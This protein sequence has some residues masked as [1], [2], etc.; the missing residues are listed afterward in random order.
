MKKIS[1]SVFSLFLFLQLFPQSQFSIHPEQK[2]SR[3]NSLDYFRGGE[4]NVVQTPLLNKYD[5][6]FYFLDLNVENDTSF[7]WGNVGIKA[8][9]LSAPLD[10]FALEFLD[11]MPIDSVFI[12]NIPRN[13]LRE[14][15]EIFIPIDPPID[16]GAVFSAK[17]YYH[18][19]PETGD[20]FSGG[21]TSR[22]DSTW[23]KHVTWSLSEPFYARSWWPV[24]QVL[25]DK[26]DSVWVFITTDSSN[27]AGSEGLLTQVVPL[28]PKHRFEW[29]SKYPIDYYL[30]SFAV[31][32]YQDY[33]I[34]AHPDGMGGDSLLI[35]NF[36]YDAPGCLEH[37]K[38]NLDR[39]VEIIELF[40]NL[41][42]LYPF[43]QEKYGHCLVPLGGGMEHQTMTT[44]GGFGLGIVAHE[45]GHMWF[46]DH[47]TCATW[48]D[49]WVNEGFATY[50]DYL[51]HEKIAGPPWPGI[52]MKNT[53]AYVISQPDGSIY[54]PPEEIT[55]D[56][57]HRIFDPLLSYNKGALILHMIRY[58]LHDDDL[59]FQVYKNYQTEF[60]DSVATADDFLDVL[61]ATSGQNFDQFFDQWF[62]G[63]GYPIYQIDWSIHNDT[64]LII[65]NQ[66]AS[67]P[68]KTPFFNMKLPIKLYF[69]DGTDTLIEIDQTQ[70]SVSKI[71]MVSTGVDS[72]KVDPDLWVIKKVDAINGVGE[73][74]SL[75]DLRISPNPFHHFI[76]IQ[77]VKNNTFDVRISNIQGQQVYKRSFSS[78]VETIRTDK[79]KSGVYLIRVQSGNSEKSFKFI[80]NQ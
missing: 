65:S 72:L 4:K 74:N 20:F 11:G 26:A 6:G 73:N 46:G 59:F 40:S 69:N 34:Y 17:I 47:V 21:V 9:A 79:L 64:V 44:L 1:L 25:A 66:T 29:K 18:G 16:S 56:N 28:G 37:Y 52:W 41:Y 39:T 27:M 22:Y 13:V 53:H 12:N 35:Q 75:D 62:Y 71:V 55:Y 54:I 68:E 31:A 14:N 7:L 70:P 30:I 8:R 32:D 5:V 67:A 78:G 38:N 43:H 50:S 23:N 10:T 19:T 76:R 60:A 57:I 36:I 48:S 80:K 61:N 63:E 45:L 51:A 77:G 42:S 33:S 58:L 24:K 49:I 3:A 2:C 15:D